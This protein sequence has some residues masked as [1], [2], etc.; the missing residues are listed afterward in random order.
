MIFY[1]Q[2]INAYM[3]LFAKRIPLCVDIDPNAGL[4]AIVDS[5]FFVSIN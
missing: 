2:H 1:L 4:F 3:C 5:Y